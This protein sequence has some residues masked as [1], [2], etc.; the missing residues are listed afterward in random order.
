M[1][2]CSFKVHVLLLSLNTPVKW[3]AFVFPDVVRF[4]NTYSYLRS[5]TIKYLIEVL[6]PELE[7]TE[8]YTFDRSDVKEEKSDYVLSDNTYL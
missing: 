2:F 6:E 1:T 3:L 5:K 7:E 4:D 8:A